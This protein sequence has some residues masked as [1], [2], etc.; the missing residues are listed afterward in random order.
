[1]KLSIKPLVFA[2][3]SGILVF[4]AVTV[5]SK[6]NRGN[7]DYTQSVLSTE[8]HVN[9]SQGLTVGGT[10]LIKVT[11]RGHHKT[12]LTTFQRNG[13]SYGVVWLAP[14]NGYGGGGVHV[15]NFTKDELEVRLLKSKID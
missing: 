6:N 14:E 15:V 8:N 12:V 1:M 11:G 7:N 3:L 4:I 10:T 5:F 9:P 13:M 2:I